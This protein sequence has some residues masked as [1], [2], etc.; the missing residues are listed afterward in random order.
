[1][2]HTLRKYLSSRGSALFMVL[3]TMTALMIAAMA[4]YF[5]VISSR[6][7]QYAV[8]YEEQSYQSAV[9][10]TDAIIAGLNNGKLGDLQSAVLALTPGDATTSTFSTNG[11]N[12]KTF[13]ESGTKDDDDQMG[14]YDINV[15]RLADSDGCWVYDFGVTC[16]VNGV[17]ETTHTMVRMKKSDTDPPPASNLFTA[18]GYTPNTNYMDRGTYYADVDIDAQNV[19]I[20]TKANADKTETGDVYSGPVFKG[21]LTCAGTAE[22]YGIGNPGSVPPREWTFGG[23]LIL[24]GGAAQALNMYGTA[25]KPGVIFVGGDLYAETETRSL[26]IQ[27]NDIMYVQGDVH[28]R[29]IVVNGKLFVGG[30]IYVDQKKINDPSSDNYHP[31][32]QGNAIQKWAGSN[33]SVIVTQNKD[34]NIREKD[35]TIIT[36]FARWQDVK[37]GEIL[38][39]TW[40]ET[41]DL[42]V[43]YKS[44]DAVSDAITSNIGSISYPIWTVD[45]A[46]DTKIKGVTHEKV[47]YNTAGDSNVDHVTYEGETI[48]KSAVFTSEEL[49]W[50]PSHNACIIDD[51]VDAA[52]DKNNIYKKDGS[53]PGETEAS[54][55]PGSFGTY[56]IIVDTGDSVENV[57][58]LGLSANRTE[59]LDSSTTL[60]MFAWS[61]SNNY[62]YSN[63]WNYRTNVIVRGRGSLVMSLPEGVVYQSSTGDF[64]GHENWF[65]L[66][67][68]TVTQDGDMLKYSYITSSIESTIINNQFIHVKCDGATKCDVDGTLK[69]YTDF[70]GKEAQGYYCKTHECY[71]KEKDPVDGK[72]GCENH[73]GRKEIDAYLAKNSFKYHDKHYPKTNAEIATDTEYG[74]NVDKNGDFIYPTVNVWLV[75]K[76][77]NADIRLTSTLGKILKYDAT[78]PSDT[79]TTVTDADGTETTTKVHTTISEKGGKRIITV[80]TTVTIKYVDGTSTTTT[81]TETFEDRKIGFV[82]S[83]TFMGYVYAPYMSFAADAGSGGG[84]GGTRVVGGL[85]VSDVKV[86]DWN[87]YIFCIPEKTY[88]EI[89]SLSTLSEDNPGKQGDVSW[90]VY[91]H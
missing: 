79:T 67:G 40:G 62:D 50:T 11:N 10:I 60:D 21:G 86:N 78:P 53:H 9:S 49:I 35:G 64:I 71:V 70:N 42:D 47:V 27:E 51:I 82:Q 52:Y 13:S 91:G 16:S 31:E 7:V 37:N 25:E 85:I 44:T 66:L 41:A 56:T 5:S 15:T 72:C 24:H 26:V 36:D 81:T 6:Q 83:N 74:L 48:K 30:N 54:N 65:Y 18:T 80:T 34:S 43:P 33:K 39:K 57:F 2:T 20:S 69:T 55:F 58:Y 89:G 84:A 90:R 4:M 75:S 17:Q 61:P 8:F 19:I 14:A 63:E 22:I 32:W 23:D 3:S 68:G 88:A 28:A 45:W 77:N 29:Q 73:V 76:D 87:S 12:F 38:H 1:M 46:K 59:S